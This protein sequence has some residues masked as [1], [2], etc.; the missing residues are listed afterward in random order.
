M[1][2]L[3]IYLKTKQNMLF[4]PYVKYYSKHN[5]QI[6]SVYYILNI[7]IV[8]LCITII[9]KNSFSITFFIYLTNTSTCFLFFKVNC[10]PKYY[11]IITIKNY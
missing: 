10:S 11:N 6:I 5:L 2:I 3:Y 9:H 1:Q 7:N 8:Q 4:G